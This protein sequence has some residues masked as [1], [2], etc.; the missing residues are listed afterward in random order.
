MAAA[1]VVV[2]V[3]V[4]AGEAAEGGSS[5]N[6]LSGRDD[7]PSWLISFAL[8][9]LGEKA[10]RVTRTALAAGC[11]DCEPLPLSLPP[12]LVAPLPV[13]RA[14]DPTC[15]KL[16]RAFVAVGT[17]EASAPAPPLPPVDAA[18]AAFEPPEP[19][20]EEAERTHG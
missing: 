15:V 16:K 12:A 19:L 8:A 13:V 18:L 9:S 6:A 7:A 14:G 11:C 10:A 17:D 2:V 20:M 5:D 1:L 3:A 4:V